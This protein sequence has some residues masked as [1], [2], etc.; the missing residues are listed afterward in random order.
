MTT[1]HLSYRNNKIR[2]IK[3]IGIITF[4]VPGTMKGK[5]LVKFKR[6]YEY[7]KKF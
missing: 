2:V 3:D 7:S 6:H 5:D 4:V 1:I